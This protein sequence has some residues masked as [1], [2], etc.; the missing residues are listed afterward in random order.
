MTNLIGNDLGPIMLAVIVG[1]PL[2]QLV[3]ALL[4]KG[5]RRRLLAAVDDVLSEGP[6]APSDKAWLRDE[7]DTSSGTHLLIVS[8]FAPF[9]IFGAVALGLYDGLSIKRKPARSAQNLS[10]RIENLSAELEETRLRLERMDAKGILISQG[11]DP[12]DGKL[13]DDPRRRA[14]SSLTYSVETWSHPI[15]ALWIFF[16]LIVAVPFVLVGYAISGTIA[17]FLKNLWEPLRALL[18]GTF[19]HSAHRA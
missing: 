17:P 4:L 14:I 15:A 12:R 13:W 10:D 3:A 2:V 16:W 11:V 8:F 7:I 5:T 6:L 19:G 18:I 1:F 9:A